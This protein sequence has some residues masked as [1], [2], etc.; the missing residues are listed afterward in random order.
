MMNFTP[1]LKT[2]LSGQVFAKLPA[3]TVDSDDRRF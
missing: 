1:F 3:D 2:P